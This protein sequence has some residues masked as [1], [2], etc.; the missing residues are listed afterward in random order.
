[1]SRENTD[2]K[3]DEENGRENTDGKIDEENGREKH[4]M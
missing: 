1:M 4:R 3:I 2:G